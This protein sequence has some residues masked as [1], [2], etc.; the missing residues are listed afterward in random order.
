MSLLP[1]GINTT[2]V[3]GIAAP[4]MLN[5]PSKLKATL[6]SA[7]STSGHEIVS[8]LLSAAMGVSSPVYEPTNNCDV[9]PLPNTFFDTTQPA[10][11]VTVIAATTPCNSAAAKLN[12]RSALSTATSPTFT[13]NVTRPLANTTLAIEKLLISSPNYCS[14]ENPQQRKSWRTVEVTLKLAY[15]TARLTA[16]DRHKEV[17][18]YCTLGRR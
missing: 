16:R 15:A 18:T 9:E 4:S 13:S 12:V 1:G 14:Y 2:D 8:N 6:T 10:G 5:E 17:W 11:P 3:L 7:A